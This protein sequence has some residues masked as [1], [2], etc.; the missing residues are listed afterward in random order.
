M[1]YYCLHTNLR[2]RPSAIDSIRKKLAPIQG[3]T[4]DIW[5]NHE[6][7]NGKTIHRYPSI[8][9]KIWKHQFAI[10]ALPYAEDSFFELIK[11]MPLKISGFPV[12][13][14][15]RVEKFPLHIGLQP[16]PI[17]YR[18]DNWLP[19][20]SDYFKL[21]QA[22][23]AE[24]N[25]PVGK[26]YID[27]PVLLTFLAGILKEQLHKQA[28]SLGVSIDPTLLSVAISEQP[29]KHSLVNV[30]SM[31]WSKMS[32]LEFEVNLDWPSHLGI[33]KRTSIGFGMLK[34]I[35]NK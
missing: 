31:R 19:M 15:L 17:R 22:L 24:L 7:D 28:Y 3:R 32:S 26:P 21:Y 25:E 18:C 27:H 12:I 34:K 23:C 8:Q 4:D 20:D 14:M 11:K 9:Y 29:L 10:V 16:H 1:Y 5:H 13:D 30:S 6:L 35:S 33:G 2:I